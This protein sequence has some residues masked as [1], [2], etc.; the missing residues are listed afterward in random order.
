MKQSPEANVQVLLQQAEGSMSRVRTGWVGLRSL[1]LSEVS[2][3]SRVSMQT[4]YILLSLQISGPGSA[5]VLLPSR[6]KVCMCPSAHYRFLTE[7]RR[8]EAGSISLVVVEQKC[9]FL[10]PRYVL[11]KMFV[12]KRFR[13]EFA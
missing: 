4:G 1:P 10:T 3:R 8:K 9:V 12:G 5:A 11:L 13:G 2:L 6:K 7:S